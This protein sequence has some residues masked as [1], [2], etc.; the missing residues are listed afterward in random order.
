MKSP[1]YTKVVIGRIIE[2]KNDGSTNKQIADAIGTT[3]G[4]VTARISQLG[5][6]RNPQDTRDK[7]STVR[8]ASWIIEKCIT[9]AARR[10]LSPPDLIRLLMERIVNDDLFEAILDDGE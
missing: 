6:A 9:P 2:M 10:D 8:F 7:R 4:S 5:L 3:E 1:I